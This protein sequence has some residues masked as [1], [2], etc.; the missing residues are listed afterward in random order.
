MS[1]VAPEPAKNESL[2]GSVIPPTWF[3]DLTTPP[4]DSIWRRARIAVR[5]AR[6]IV[7]V[8]YSVP[9]TDLFSRSLFKVEAGSKLR[10]E[11]LDL[12]VVVNPNRE[13]RRGFVELVRG[14]LE[15][16]T[17]ILEL[18]RLKDLDDLL[19]AGDGGATP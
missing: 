13:A 2:E 7:V 15:P 6:I 16:R 1:L 10:E 9:P 14:G 11:K 17:R 12:L 4:F 3:K 19:K 8:G 5:S 18:P